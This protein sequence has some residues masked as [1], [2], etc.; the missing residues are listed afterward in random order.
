MS[1]YYYTVVH[2][3]VPVVPCGIWR[4]RSL[5]WSVPSLA[6]FS[7]TLRVSSSKS[8]YGCCHCGESGRDWQVSTQSAVSGRADKMPVNESRWRIRLTVRVGPIWYMSISVHRGIPLRY[9]F[10][11]VHLRFNSVHRK[12]WRAISEHHKY[13]FGRGYFYGL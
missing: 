4:L 11:S 3:V 2:A 9:M 1:V 10:N 7:I 6:V 8:C 12:F 5:E 13:V